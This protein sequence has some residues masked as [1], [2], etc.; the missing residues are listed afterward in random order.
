MR[1]NVQFALSTISACLLGALAAPA[2]ATLGLMQVPPTSV[3]PP[4]PNVLVT[5]DDS[6][7]MGGEIPYDASVTY[8]VPPGANGLQFRADSALPRAYSNAYGNTN[9]VRLNTN[10][11]AARFQNAYN[12]LTTDEQRRNYINWYGFY[13]TR[14]MAMKASVM[15]AFSPSIVPDGRFRVAWQALNST[16]GGTTFPTNNTCAQSRSIQPLEGSHRDAFFTWVQQVPANGGTPLRAAYR[17]A[18][19]YMQVAGVNGPWADRPTPMSG[20]S[21]AP[22][23]S[24]RR[25]YHVMFTDGQWN[26]GAAGYGNADNQARTFPD[27]TA[28]TVTAPYRGPVNGGDQNLSDVAFQYWAT[29]LQTG[30]GWI[31]NVPKITKRTGTETYGTTTLT[32]YWNPK[33]N[34]ATWQH[35]VLY[36]IGFGEAAQLTN[37]AWAG[38][39]TAGAGF[40]QIVSGTREWPSLPEGGNLA[41]REYDLWHAAVNTRGD[42]FPATDQKALTS[43]FQRIVAEIL[44][45]N[46]ATGGAASALTTAA[47]D[48]QVVRAGFD[49]APTFRAVV[50]GFGLSGGQI[51]TTAS[52]NAQ[53]AVTAQ[54]PNARV[55]L[56]ASTP[57]TGAPFRWANLSAFQQL[58]LNRNLGNA[59]DGRGPDRLNFLRG[60]AAKENSPAN[61][62][63][64]T[65]T[66]RWRQNAVIGTVVNS[67]PRIVSVPRAGYSD[68]DYRAFRTANVSRTPVAYFGANDGLLYGINANTGASVL[69]YVPRGVYSKIS[70]YTDPTFQHRYF[71][72]GP[73]FV[74]DIKDGATWK[75][76]LVGGLGAGGRGVF[77]LDVTNPT[78]F[79]E[80]N[81]ATLVKFDYTAAG[82]PLPTTPIDLATPLG[83]DNAG[84]PFATELNTDMGHIIGDP[85]RDAFIGRNLQISKMENDRWALIIGNGVN[86]PNERAA[87]YIIYLDGAG[88]YRKILAETATGGNNGLMTPMPVD[89]DGDGRVDTVYAG[90]LRGRVWKFNLS[91]SNDSS[92]GLANAQPLINAGRPITSAPAVTTHPEGGLFITFGTGQLLT[93]PDKSS[94]ATESLYGVWD[95]AGV[96]YP[97]N[98]SSLVSRTLTSAS[99]T[100][101]TNNGQARVLATRAADVDYSTR[102][103]WKIDLGV[104][105]ER[106]IFNPIISGPFGFFSTTVPIEGQTCLEGS[107]TGSFLAFDIFNAKPP[108]TPMIDIN[109]D[110]IFDSGDTVT[111]QDAMGRAGPAGK[112]VGLVATPDVTV[113]G[114]CP[115]LAVGAQSSIA[116]RICTGLGRRAWRDLTP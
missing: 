50:Q 40:A 69:G 63:D 23:L 67:E 15:T 105:G 72:D 54:D 89:T 96:T 27:G 41:N 19:N 37:P 45:Q 107:Q 20:P 36:G 28:Y 86:S 94:V 38:N 97:I 111:N 8:V 115:G 80:A 65:A 100:T 77:A 18:G 66:F 46:A 88:G 24:C 26:E 47:S 53:T 92:W 61:S 93:F 103:G 116:V 58:A 14:N 6:G 113:G 56:T 112:L 51:A 22:I 48:F 114:P 98:T 7:S 87:L 70:D 102:L 101:Q 49:A 39:T 79:S 21:E 2:S 12:A 11:V 25:S 10:D 32:E 106:V 81:A 5:L 17:R 13:R 60:S 104:A 75:T 82:D 85:A 76:I 71:V 4:P 84:V 108:A 110:N 78:N 29:D 90:D 74:G 64:L 33:N 52:W 83:A 30:T 57:L 55:V 34:P 95:K 44:A 42:L 99:Q 109:G 68:S 3:T 31:N 16:C 62:A 43:A 91:A 73:V 35:L 9:T 59:N 1:R